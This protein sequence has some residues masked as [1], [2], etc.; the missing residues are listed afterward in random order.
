MDDGLKI[1][2][3]SHKQCADLAAIGDKAMKTEKYACVMTR[4][5]QMGSSS[6]V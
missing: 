4:T 2:D 1:R 3:G 5:M 6:V